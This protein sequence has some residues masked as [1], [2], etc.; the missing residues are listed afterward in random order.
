MSKNINKS[1]KQLAILKD[2]HFRRIELSDIILVMNVNNYI[3]NS[4]NLEIEYAKNLRKEIVYF[5]DLIIEDTSIT[6]N[7]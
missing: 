7:I 1:E 2:E 3:G 6:K 5:T 4:T